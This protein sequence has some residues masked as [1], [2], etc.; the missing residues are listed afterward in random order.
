MDFAAAS[1]SKWTTKRPGKDI[2][3]KKKMES[4][5]DVYLYKT[6]K[7]T[8][9]YVVLIVT[10]RPFSTLKVYFVV[11]TQWKCFVCAYTA[12]EK[13]DRFETIFELGASVFCL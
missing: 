1:E 9:I 5:S 12:V 10:L 3:Q 6:F 7:P 2:N 8:C 4:F 13:S 11:C